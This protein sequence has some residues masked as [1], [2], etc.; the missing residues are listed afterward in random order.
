MKWQKIDKVPKAGSSIWVWNTITQKQELFIVNP[1][2]EWKKE[3]F[4]VH[5]AKMWAYVF[6]ADSSA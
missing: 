3:K 5:L 2:E 6:E 4:P 1:E